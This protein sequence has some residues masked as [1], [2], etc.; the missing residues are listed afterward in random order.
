MTKN[1]SFYERE[2][3]KRIVFSGFSMLLPARKMVYIYP[4]SKDKLEYLR[5]FFFILVTTFFE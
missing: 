5:S 3:S 2:E 4:F 1:N